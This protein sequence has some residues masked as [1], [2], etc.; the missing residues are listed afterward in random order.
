[1]GDMAVL[2]CLLLGTWLG[3]REV[4]MGTIWSLLSSMP[5]VSECKGNDYGLHSTHL[6][7]T[8]LMWT[9]VKV[10]VV[11]DDVG[12]VVALCQC[13][14]GLLCSHGWWLS[15]PLVFCHCQ[16]QMIGTLVICWLSANTATSP[17]VHIFVFHV[18][19]NFCKRFLYFLSHFYL[20]AHYD[21]F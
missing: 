6:S 16:L 5:W 10:G 1:M 7:P 3:K 12:D 15:L 20:L 9:V 18:S 8:P 17:M 2:S 13:C 11:L 21:L 19:E 14:W 4:E